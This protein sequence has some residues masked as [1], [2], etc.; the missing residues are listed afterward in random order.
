MQMDFK[1]SDVSFA[2]KQYHPP[3]NRH[4]RHMT[5]KQM[6]AEVFQSLRLQKMM[7]E[8]SFDCHTVAVCDFELVLPTVL[9]GS[10]GER[11]RDRGGG[12]GGENVGRRNR[13]QVLLSSNQDN[14]INTA[15]TNTQ[16]AGCY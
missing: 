1:T 5:P 11:Y 2:L 4:R 3:P 12:E 8:V 13:S 16:S 9:L 7:A 15:W 14:S 6:K 10:R